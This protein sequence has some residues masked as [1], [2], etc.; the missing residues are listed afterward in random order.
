MSISLMRS[1][2]IAGV[3]HA[4]APEA[5]H[6]DDGSSWRSALYI[7]VPSPGTKHYLTK[8][9]LTKTSILA[10][11]IFYKII[12][13]L[14][15]IEVMWFGT[16][17]DGVCLRRSI[18]SWWRRCSPIRGMPWSTSGWRTRSTTSLPAAL[19]Q[20]WTANRRWPSSRAWRSLL[21]MWEG[22]CV[23]N[24]PLSPATVHSS[25]PSPPPLPL[26]EA[27]H[28]AKPWRC[29]AQHRMRCLSAL[30][31]GLQTRMPPERREAGEGREGAASGPWSDRCLLCHWE[32]LRWTFMKCAGVIFLKTD[33]FIP[34]LHLVFCRRFFSSAFVFG[35]SRLRSSR[36]YSDNRAVPCRAA[37]MVPGIVSC[38]CHDN[39]KA[40]L[41]ETLIAGRPFW[42]TKSLLRLR[43]YIYF[44]KKQ[45]MK[46][47]KRTEKFL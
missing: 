18:Q 43:L 41:N 26:R 7:S 32:V 8:I 40:F 14:W 47:F 39:E 19:L 27:F 46:V 24:K 9:K 17:S 29:S 38:G 34:L 11:S 37:L 45:K 44:W 5:Q 35:F 6:W 10:G 2:S 16:V 36:V 20:P 3:W 23:S 4:C 30:P 21:P 42:K 31:M 22:F 28:H 13:I 1:S 15:H 12:W 25:F 33:P